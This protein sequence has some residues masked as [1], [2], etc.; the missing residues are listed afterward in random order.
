MPSLIELHE[1][2][3]HI[4]LIAVRGTEFRVHKR[5]DAGE[6]SLVVCLGADRSI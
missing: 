5:I 6:G 2:G 1:V 4:Q 3:E